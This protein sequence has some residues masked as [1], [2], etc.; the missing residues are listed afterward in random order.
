MNQN[1][2][3]SKT[4]KHIF[5]NWAALANT[6]SQRKIREKCGNT[7]KWKKIK[8]KTQHIKMYGI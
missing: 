1:E 8:D 5:G 7:L 4:K 6:M 3:I 2:K